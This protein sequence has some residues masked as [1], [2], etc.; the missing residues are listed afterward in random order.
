MRPPNFARLNHV[1]IPATKEGRDRLRGGWVGKLGWPIVAI[2]GSLTDEGRMVATLVTVG[3]VFGIDTRN[4]ELYLLWALLTAAVMA[5]LVVR[6]L[7]RLEGVRASVAVPRRVL[8]GEELVFAVTLENQGPRDASAVRVTGPF[9]PWDGSWVT[10]SGGVSRLARGQSAR[11]ELRAR[12]VSRGEHHLDSFRAAAVVPF[13]LARGPSLAT[14][15]ARFLVLPRI[16]RVTRVTIPQTRRDQAGGIALASK[17]GESMELAGVRP[18]RA[19]DPVRLLHAR[20]WARLGQPIVR[21]YQEEQFKRVAVVVDLDPGDEW[22]SEAAISLA[23][24]IVSHLARGEAIIDLLVAGEKLHDLTL[25]RNLG[26]LEQALELLA[27]L[28]L[29]GGKASDAGRVLARLEPHFDRLSAVVV[30][31]AG[32]GAAAQVAARVRAMGIGCVWYRVDD[33]G[34]GAKTAG[35][36]MVDPG[37]I[38]RGEE[39]AL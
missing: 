34:P 25:G 30:V 26:F 17:T 32:A 37:T 12:F 1:L 21:E 39:I 5:S 15:G 35:A 8:V 29:G 33:A 18:Y 10:Y 27:C 23:A 28:E 16:A 6:P 3:G 13:G 9:L 2:Y 14:G 11:V 19:G 20:S 24:G 38:E 31:D 36:V 4:T 7:F 22:R